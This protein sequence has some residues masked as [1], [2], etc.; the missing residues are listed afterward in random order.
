MNLVFSSKFWNV[1]RN[2]HDKLSTFKSQDEQRTQNSH[3]APRKRRGRMFMQYNSFLHHSCIDPE[4]YLPLSRHS[5][6]IF[7]NLAAE[8]GRPVFAELGGE[9]VTLLWLADVG[10]D[11]ENCP[12]GRPLTSVLLLESVRFG[13]MPWWWRSCEVEGGLGTGWASVP[14]DIRR[15][16]SE[17]FSSKEACFFDSESL[18][19]GCLWRRTKKVN[20]KD[21]LQ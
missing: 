13:T 5:T 4:I 7:R 14:V 18:R 2:S 21:R 20:I 9:G 19:F 16:W 10:G 8:V 15:L 1:S 11:G 17:G 3:E 12:L 6:T